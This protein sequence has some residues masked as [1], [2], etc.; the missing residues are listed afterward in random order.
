MII[1]SRDRNGLQKSW[2][3]WRL[4][5]T[6]LNIIALLLSAILS[7]HYLSGESLAGCIGGSSCETVLDSRWAMLGGV[8]PISSLAVGT[9]LS[10][11]VAG[12]FIGS[13]TD[14]SIRRVA[15]RVMLVLAG[16]IAGSAIWFIIIQKWVIENFCMYCM[17]LHSTG[18]LISALIIWRSV[19]EFD[20]HINAKKVINTTSVQRVSAA[21][22]SPVIRLLPA[23]VFTF[24]GV[25]FA[26]LMAT[27]QVVIKPETQYLKSKSSINLPAMDYHA[28][29]MVGSPDAPYVV[30]LLFDYECP[31]C[32]Q[33][34]LMLDEAVRRYHGELAFALCPS[35]LNTGCNPYIT[36]NVDDFKNSCELARISLAV[37]VADRGAFP[38]FDNWM[39]TFDSGD[40]WHPRGLEAARTK[41]VELVGQ[42]KF[43]AALNDSW[44]DKYLQIC[45]QIYGKAIQ[46]GTGG[47]P[48]LVFGSNWVIPEPDNENDLLQILQKSFSIP[49]P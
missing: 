31:H 43:G 25:I 37:W 39:F 3:W 34:H 23:T 47:V 10:L 6:G 5:L 20:N 15:W 7:W 17:S 21:K 14:V 36:R 19:K 26:G 8:L 32:Q 27:S 38:A 18:L 24:C 12:F 13:A 30:I 41:A 28:V 1:K 2:P 48:K 9:Y 46:G 44:I 45:T 22:P 29:P 42:A 35:P 16:S 4:A 40:R 49:K 33:I 11:L